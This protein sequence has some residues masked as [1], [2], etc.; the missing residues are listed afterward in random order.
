MKLL[1]FLCLTDA[2]QERERIAKQPAGAA[3]KDCLLN[4]FDNFVAYRNG[5]VEVD[6]YENRLDE[7]EFSLFT[8]ESGRLKLRTE[9]LASRAKNI[10]EETNSEVQEAIESALSELRGRGSKIVPNKSILEQDTTA[11]VELSH[12]LTPDVWP[13]CFYY[14][15]LGGNISQLFQRNRAL[16]E[17]EVLEF[18]KQ[19]M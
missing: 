10:L 19:L 3:P 16:L 4:T 13:A 12:N 11:V 15:K 7:G 6:I 8:F 1:Y 9:G 2:K 5:P 14:D 18:E 17:A